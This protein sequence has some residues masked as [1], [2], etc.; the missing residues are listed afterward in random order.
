M[1]IFC[2]SNFASQ[3]GHQDSHCGFNPP[4]GFFA[5]RTRLA[6][7]DADVSSR[8][9]QSAVRI[10]C[11][12]NADRPNHVSARASKFQSAVRI[13]CFSNPD[14]RLQILEAIGA[15][16]IR[17]A[18]FLL[19]ELYVHK[20]WTGFCA[21]SIRR[22]DFLLFERDNTQI[23]RFHISI[24]SIRRA[25]FLLFEPSTRGSS[26]HTSAFQSAVRIFCFS[27]RAAT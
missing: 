20:P 22:A 2:F 10:F 8:A 16:S 15:V 12:S 19:F 17:R 24:V 27:N 4:C 1:R 25:D 9:F 14:L 5:F 26:A 13:F 7:L 23:D 3:V 18:D 21:V 6:H 11:F